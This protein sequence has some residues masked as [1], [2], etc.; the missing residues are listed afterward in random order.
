MK[1][2][3]IFAGL[4][5]VSLAIASLF[6]GVAELS[7]TQLL[8]PNSLDS[9]ILYT[10]RIPRLLAITLAGAGLSIAGLIMQQ[11]VQNRFAAP[12]TTG[13]I[14]FA[15]L[16]YI[17]ALVYFVDASSWVH[18]I[19]IFCFAIAGTLVFV[20]FLQTLK[21]K[22][23]VLVPLIGIMYGNVISALTTFYAYQ[24]DLVQTLGAWTVANFASVLKGNYEFL[25]LAVPVSLLAYTYA[26]KFSATGVGETFA[27]NI[28]INYQ[29]IVMFGVVLV[30]VLSSTVVMIVGMIPFLGLIVPNVVSLFFGDNMRRNLPWTAFF[31]VVLV[32]SCDIF[33]RLI[34]FPYE[35]P[36]S[37]VISI[38]GGSLFIYL[39]LRDKANA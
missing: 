33:G 17:V 11:I 38:I 28:G 18:L 29:K 20:R 4:T 10:S 13:T 15:M 39:I 7:F 19:I 12:S 9:N 16:G 1:L 22:S 3:H 6:V 31:G 35:V 37:M 32:L 34:I 24:Y 2:S 8:D 36:I 5:L 14:D 27:K 30:A 26:H 25:Y 21:F 23:T